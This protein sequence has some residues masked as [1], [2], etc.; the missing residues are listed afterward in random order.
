MIPQA[1][2]PDREAGGEYQV[3]TADP[4][5]DKDRARVQKRPEHQRE[6]DREIDHVL[7]QIIS[8]NQI[9]GVYPEHGVPILRTEPRRKRLVI[10]RPV[11][12]SFQRGTDP[13]LR[14]NRKAVSQLTTRS[15]RK[16]TR[17]NSSH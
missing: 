2:E 10:T 3:D 6:P 13:A 5:G 15:D 17:L 11:R 8:E 12:P 16:N 14:Q 7:H 1:A 9:E 4:A